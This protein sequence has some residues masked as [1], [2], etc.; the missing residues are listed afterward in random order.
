MDIQ[1]KLNEARKELAECQKIIDHYSALHE[2]L[3]LE[4]VE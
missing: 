1:Q 2:N 4:E 3:A